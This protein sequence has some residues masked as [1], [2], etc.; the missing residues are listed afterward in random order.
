MPVRQTA[1]KAVGARAEQRALHQITNGVIG[2]Q[3]VNRLHPGRTADQL[4]GMLAAALEQ[5]RHGLADAGLIELQL[6]LVQQGLQAGKAVRL[7]CDSVAEDRPHINRLYSESI[8]K[9]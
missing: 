3:N 4:T 2:C 5:H 7:L 9:P 8:I 1:F 6:V